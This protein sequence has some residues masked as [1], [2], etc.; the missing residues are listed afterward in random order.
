MLLWDGGTGPSGWGSLRKGASGSLGWQGLRAP[1]GL[2]TISAS[3]WL[4]VTCHSPISETKLSFGT[5]SARH[6]I[7]KA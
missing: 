3:W 7:G 5:K 2:L 6:Q 1:L 4:L